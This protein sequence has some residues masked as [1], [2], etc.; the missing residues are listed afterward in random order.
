MRNNTVCNEYLHG[1]EGLVKFPVRISR[2][3]ATL[4]CEAM[5]LLTASGSSANIC[6]RMKGSLP[7]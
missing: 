1:N 6:I 4:Y 7:F 5:S 3:G 2:S